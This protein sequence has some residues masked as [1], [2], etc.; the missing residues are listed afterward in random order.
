M[1]RKTVLPVIGLV[2]LVASFCALIL[3]SLIILFSQGR[4]DH[5]LLR[6]IA[7]QV[8]L[9]INCAA[10]EQSPLFREE[11]QVPGQATAHEFDYLLF[12]TNGRTIAQRWYSK[13]YPPYLEEQESR[14]IPFVVML[15]NIRSVPHP[16]YATLHKVC[17]RDWNLLIHDPTGEVYRQLIFR[18]Q[19]VLYFSSCGVLSLAVFAMAYYLLRKGRE[20]KEVMQSLRAG[21]LKA[22]LPSHRFERFLELVTEFNNMVA[23]IETLIHKIQAH[24]QERLEWLGDLAH[25]LRTPLASLSAAVETLI[26]FDTNLKGAQRAQLLHAMMDDITYFQSLLNDIF[27]LASLQGTR[28]PIQLEELCCLD[29]IDKLSH[30][31]REQALAEGKELRWTRGSEEGVRFGADPHLLRRLLQNLIDNAIRYSLSWIAV[32]VDS[33]EHELRIT[34]SN[35]AMPL[36]ESD[37]KAWGKK[38]QQRRIAEAFSRERTSLG[39]G[40]SIVLQI[41]RL[42]QGQA[43][44]EQTVGEQGALV[45]VVVVWPRNLLQKHHA[46]GAW[47]EGVLVRGSDPVEE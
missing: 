17:Q 5:A 41:A 31:W 15:N 13:S 46:G 29:F 14:R 23:A 19:V 43:F 22:R 7:H 32:A 12:D 45:Q 26:D 11:M 38:R 3:S 37:L 25:D 18:R 42:H 30:S 6:E 21:N 8:S 16:V 47:I 40:S 1:R 44:M 4:P 24:E 10:P 39:L 2:M 9:G 20:A 28:R 35:D 33:S 27:F 36:S 34:V